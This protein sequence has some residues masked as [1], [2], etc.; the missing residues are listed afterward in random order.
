MEHT[1]IFFQHTDER[2]R[3]LFNVEA[4]I[5][6]DRFSE[7]Y[8]GGEALTVAYLIEV[9]NDLGL[10]VYQAPGLVRFIT[11]SQVAEMKAAALECYAE[12]FPQGELAGEG[13]GDYV[14][15]AWPAGEKLFSL[16]EIRADA[17][18]A[19]SKSYEANLF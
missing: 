11:L 5:S 14:G 7:D 18:V 13:A 9:K 4:G 19:F 6:V 1:V 12:R 8:E 10:G 2:T 16:D 17:E 15:E 3:Q